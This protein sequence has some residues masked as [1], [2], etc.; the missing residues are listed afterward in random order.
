MRCPFCGG[1]NG[2]V[3]DSRQLEE[4]NAVRRRRLCEDCGRRYNT[5]ERVELLPLT[6]IKKDQTRE[7]YDRSKIQDGMLR[8]CYKRPI[9]VEKIQDAID[10]V[11]N[12]V[13]ALGEREV[14]SNQIGELVMD[15]LKTLDEVS[16]VRFASV[17]R[18]FKDVGTF[19][20]ELKKIMG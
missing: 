11:E 3:I 19:M 1:E 17:Y 6:V 4:V 15:Q 5:F 9:P 8:A 18:E 16:Y 7:P 13:M 14:S 12:A 2:R 10:K 20:E